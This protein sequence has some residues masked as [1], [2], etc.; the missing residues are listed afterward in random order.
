MNQRA[1]LLSVDRGSTG[2]DHELNG[3]GPSDSVT[4]RAPAAW[5]M[6][7]RARTWVKRSLPSALLVAFQMAAQLRSASKS[8]WQRLG[9]V[10][11]AWRRAGKKPMLPDKIARVLFVCHGNIMRSP[12]AEA[13]LQRELPKLGAGSLKVSSAGLHAVAGRSADPRAL[14]VSREF[15]VSLVQHRAQSLTASLVDTTDLVV[16]MDTANAAEFLLLYPREKAKLFFLRQFS[17]QNPKGRDIPDPYPGDEDDMRRCCGVIED[18]VA[19]LADKLAGQAKRSESFM[20][21]YGN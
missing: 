3:S 19:G 7:K 15:G 6:G 2:S 10:M 16:V 14:T 18:C 4:N 11:R 21:G 20:T 1:A 17:R 12:V 13:M 8:P 5:G 9:S